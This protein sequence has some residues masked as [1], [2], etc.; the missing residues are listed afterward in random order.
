MLFG[1]LLVG[2]GALALLLIACGWLIG[3][4]QERPRGRHRQ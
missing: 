2:G 1:W 4:C 3:R